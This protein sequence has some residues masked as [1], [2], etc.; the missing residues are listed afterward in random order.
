MVDDLDI[1]PAPTAEEL[2]AQA[3]AEAEAKAKAEA[4]QD[5]LKTELERVNKGGRT[6]LEKLEFTKKR[7]DEQL[8]EE[9]KAQGFE[10]EPEVGD[11]DEPLTKGEFKRIQQETTIKTALQLADEID[12]ETEKELVKYHINNTIRSTGNP[13]E[14]L[15]LARALAN[16]VKNKQILEQVIQKPKAKS[17]S[18]NGGEAPFKEEEED[19]TPEQLIFTKPPFNLTKEQIKAQKPKFDK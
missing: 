12:N 16:D 17:G 15:R 8:R 2:E 9:R 1:T 4:E 11:D 6:K 5:P 19:L 18:S 13:K 3:K 7:V 10:P 14:D